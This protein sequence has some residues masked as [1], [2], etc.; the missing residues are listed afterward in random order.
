MSAAQQ[1]PTLS[2]QNLFLATPP[3]A[4]KSFYKVSTKFLQSFCKVSQRCKQTFYKVANKVGGPFG[5]CRLERNAPSTMLPPLGGRGEGAPRG[6]FWGALCFLLLDIW[7]VL[8]GH[9]AGLFGGRF[10]WRIALTSEIWFSFFGF[11]K[12]FAF[13]A[14]RLC[15][16]RNDATDSIFR[17]LGHPPAAAHCRTALTTHGRRNLFAAR[18]AHCFFR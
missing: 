15:G 5:L 3:L 8:W 1:P 12:R 17:G 11:W 10:E 2:P 9:F 13:C 18:Q 16:V 4:R 14:P 6:P 7:F